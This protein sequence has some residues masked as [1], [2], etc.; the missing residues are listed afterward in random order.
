MTGTQNHDAPSF[1]SSGV[2]GNLESIAQASQFGEAGQ[3]A[4][5]RSTIH[6]CDWLV[7]FATSSKSAS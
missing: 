3:S 4:E 5:P 2:L 6:C 7:T 1:A